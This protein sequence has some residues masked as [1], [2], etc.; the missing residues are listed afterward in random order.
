MD[1]VHK[2]GIMEVL[3]G[4]VVFG[5]DANWRSSSRRTGEEG[6]SP[7]REDDCEENGWAVVSSA[8]DSCSEDSE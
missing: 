2:H 4:L 6:A 8:D 7:H 3:L 5:E 1:P